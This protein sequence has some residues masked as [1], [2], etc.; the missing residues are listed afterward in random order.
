MLSEEEILESA[1]DL[2]PH[3]RAAAIAHGAYILAGQLSPEW[4]MRVPA[5]WDALT[6]EAKAINLSAMDVWIQHEKL[7]DSWIEA[8]QACRS[9][10]D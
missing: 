4:K 6:P 8:I 1:R 10:P 5:N 2:V 3:E 7:F 9:I